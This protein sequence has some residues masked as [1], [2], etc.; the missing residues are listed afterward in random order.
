MDIT[1]FLASL[2]NALDTNLA[3]LASKSGLTLGHLSGL[4][5]GHKPLAKPTYLKLRAISPEPL[6]HSLDLVFESGHEQSPVMRHIRDVHAYSI[7]MQE[8][9]FP[10]RLTGLIRN[11]RKKTKRYMF[12]TVFDDT[13]IIDCYLAADALGEERFSNLKELKQGERVFVEGV[14]GVNQSGDLMISAAK[15]GVLSTAFEF[16]SYVGAHVRLSTNL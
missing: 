13:G 6:Q 1:E 10:V 5:G 14:T 7:R 3:G 4:A 2:Q 15:A 16:D 11:I 8:Q 9:P 12:W